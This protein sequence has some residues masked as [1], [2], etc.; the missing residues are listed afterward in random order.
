MPTIRS[1]HMVASFHDR[2]GHWESLRLTDGVNLLHAHGPAFGI[3]VNG[4]SVLPNTRRLVTAVTEPAVRACD[5]LYVHGDM[6]I[7]H[8]IELHN[9]MPVMKQS[10]LLEVL[11][12]QSLSRRVT[13]VWLRLPGFALDE[14]RNNFLHAGSHPPRPYHPLKEPLVLNIDAQK[15]SALVAM[16]NRALKET[17]HMVAA[18]Q[19]SSLSVE[20][21]LSSEGPNLMAEFH[22]RMDEEL[23]P[24]KPLQWSG[25][26][27]AVASEPA[28]L[29]D[30][31]ERQ[32]MEF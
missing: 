5:L 30:A 13:G 26:Y 32:A 18:W 2:T 7:L 17:E 4:R 21:R 22:Q 16:E 31:K 27:V 25:H 12:S 24:G 11:T 8:R 20:I 28:V 1:P 9:A 29:L 3:S 14:R 15:T 19:R 10:I 6:R 23:I